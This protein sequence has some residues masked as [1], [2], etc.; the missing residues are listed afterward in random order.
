MTSGEQWV[1]NVCTLPTAERPLRIAE[2]D[3]VFAVV[4]RAARRAP[5]RL[6]LVLPAAMEADARDLAQR[7]S[8][9]CS[10]F[11]FDFEPTDDGVVMRIE[12]PP[13]QVEVLDAIEGRI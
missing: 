12:V 5:S 4:L 13:A 9:C 2:F 8:R 7:E 3:D 10:F 1:P 6:D 11:G